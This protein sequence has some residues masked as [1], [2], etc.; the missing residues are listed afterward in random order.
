LS[1]STQTPLRQQAVSERPTDWSQKLAFSQFDPSLGTLQ[2]IGV[3]ATADVAGS[4]SVESLEAAPSTVSA[5]LN[6]NVAVNS[7]TGVPLASVAAS[8]RN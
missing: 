2:S 6:S 3:G 1:D 7:P 8:A 4:V 5:T